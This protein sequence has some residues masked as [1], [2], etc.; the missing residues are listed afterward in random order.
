[1]QTRRA[2]HLRSLA[3][4]AF[5]LSAVAT[6]AFAAADEAGFKPIFDGKTLDGWTCVDMSYWSVEEGALTAKITPEH[7]LKH[8]RFLVWSLG[9]LDD[10]ELKFSFKVRG[11]PMANGGAQVRSEMRPDGAAVGYQADIDMAGTWVGSLWDEEKRGMLA[12]RGE[13]VTRD[14]EGKNHVTPNGDAT[15]LFEAVK[16]GDWNDYD[17][18]AVGNHFVLKINGNVTADFTDDDAA[19][20][21]MSGLLALQVHAGGPMQI[22]YKN[23]RLKRLPL[24]DGRKKI[25]MVAGHPSH[26][27]G[28]HEFN[29]G[30]KLLKKCLGGTPGVLAA[31]YHDNGWPK[32]PTAFDNANAVVLYM[33]GGGGHPVNQHLDEVDALTKKGVGLM[34]MHYAVEVP[35]SPAGEKFLQWLGGFYEDGFSTNP[36]WPLKAELQKDHPITTGVNPFELTDEWYYNIHFRE[37]MKGVTSILRGTPSDETRQGTSS[38]PKG[39]HRHIVDAKGRVETV[40]WATQRE[41]GGRGVGFTGGHVHANWGDD[42]LRKLVLNGIVWVS[43]AEVPAGGVKSSVT[44]EEL[45]ANLDKK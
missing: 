25:V 45:K 32:D 7:P 3:A 43:G 12:K 29:A 6:A 17:V 1:M 26:G 18:T 42:D 33:D 19:K 23:I 34:C 35:K 37:G 21:N 36:H 10:F 38:W 8:N 41:D 14:A 20:R 44:P 27:P 24:S 31:D 11:D 9:E 2:F 30:I 13:K 40:M 28:D 15:N 16:K 4:A 5:S 22:Q 39:P